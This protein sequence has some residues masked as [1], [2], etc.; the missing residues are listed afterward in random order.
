[1][2]TKFT[3]EIKIFE[4]FVS[5]MSLQRVLITKN[6][7]TIFVRAH[8]VMSWMCLTDVV[9]QVLLGGT[10]YFTI[11]LTGPNFVDFTGGSSSV[12]E[13]VAVEE[14]LFLEKEATVKGFGCVGTSS[15]VMVAI[16][17]TRSVLILSCVLPG[18]DL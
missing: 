18:D 4:M 1:M 13:I 3:R 11:T 10:L 5:E 8:P 17:D 12:V 15:E 6:F 7:V 9:L 2:V 16:P 14:V